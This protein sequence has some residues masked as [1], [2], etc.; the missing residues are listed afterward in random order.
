MWRR[1]SWS[2]WE[3]CRKFRLQEH[4][5]KQNGTKLVYYPP[6]YKRKITCHYVLNSFSALMECIELFRYQFITFILEAFQQFTE[7]GHRPAPYNYALARKILPHMASRRAQCTIS[8]KLIIELFCRLLHQM[9]Q[10][11]VNSRKGRKLKLP[12]VWNV[13][14]MRSILR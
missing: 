9:R 4:L 3:K 13:F 10:Q 11:E 1:N 12:E 2:R 7:R 8:I 5:H 14:C 6:L